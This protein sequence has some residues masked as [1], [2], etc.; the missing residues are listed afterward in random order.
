VN[1]VYTFG[2]TK[3]VY[4]PGVDLAKKYDEV[5]VGKQW[6]KLLADL[7]LPEMGD[8]EDNLFRGTTREELSESYLDSIS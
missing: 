1:K 8:I 5:V 4:Q 6:L 3:D 2:Y 7:D